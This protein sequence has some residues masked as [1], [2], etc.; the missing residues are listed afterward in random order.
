MNLIEVGKKDGPQIKVRFKICAAGST[1]WVGW[2]VGGR[3]LDCPARGGLGFL[4]MEHSH[5]FSGLGI[6]TERTERPGGPRPDA[7]CYSVFPDSCYGIRLSAMDSDDES[8]CD[9]HYSSAVESTD[10]S[11]VH[12][13][14]GVPLVYDGDPITISQG[15]G[16]WVP[17]VAAARHCVPVHRADRRAARHPECEVDLRRSSN[18]R[19]SKS[20]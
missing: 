9:L 15:E 19:T 6:H 7:D 2:I 20:R 17:V 18:Q 5:C 10:S 4:P 3:V 1:D 16:A 8:D 14:K 11:Y 12:A 13:S